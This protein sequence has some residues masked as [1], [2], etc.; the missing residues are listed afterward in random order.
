MR[1]HTELDYIPQNRVEYGIVYFFMKD[2]IQSNF[3]FK[4]G[5]P[6]YYLDF[7]D[8]GKIRISVF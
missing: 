8:S 2:Y 1:E 7:V 5:V 4:I 6:K 3:V